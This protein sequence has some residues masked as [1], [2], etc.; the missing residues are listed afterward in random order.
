MSFRGLFWNLRGLANDKTINMLQN[1]I[2]EHQPNFLFL[3]EPMTSFS[4][5]HAT[6]FL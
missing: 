6:F 4:S 1:L 3:A 2:V 5:Y